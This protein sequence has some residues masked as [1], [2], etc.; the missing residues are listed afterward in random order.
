MFS[1]STAAQNLAFVLSSSGVDPADLIKRSD[2]QSEGEYYIALAK[3]AEA[4]DNPKV[5]SAL[6]KVK[7][8]E[9]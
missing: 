3:A 6:V 7:Q 5:R 2:Y 4:L 1:N 9:E 8:Q